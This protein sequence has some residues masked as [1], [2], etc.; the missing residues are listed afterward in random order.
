MEPS[1]QSHTAL[2]AGCR[3]GFYLEISLPPST[4]KENPG[5]RVRLEAQKSISSLENELNWGE[6]VSS[7][8]PVF[9]DDDAGQPVL[10]TPGG[11][12]PCESLNVNEFIC[13]SQHPVFLISKPRLRE[14]HSLV[15]GHIVPK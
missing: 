15:P 3:S 1:A 6:E 11:P 9:C 7:D 12:G 10:S 2:A 5:K 8:K 4:V 13:S 14:V